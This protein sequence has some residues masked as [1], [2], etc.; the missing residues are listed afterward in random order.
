MNFIKLLFASLLII[1]A[2]ISIVNAQEE[3]KPEFPGGIKAFN[4]YI[5][6]N[7]KYPEVANLVGLEGKVYISFVITKNGSITDVKPIKCLGAGCESEAVRVI[8]MS[9]RWKHGTQYGRPVKFQYTVPVS[10]DLNSKKTHNLPEGSE[11][12][13]LR[14]C[15]LY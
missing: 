4:K 6:G 13:K 14:I 8:S 15:I 5:A 7:L 10:F 2:S 1:G 12:I 3:Q 11:K 9:P